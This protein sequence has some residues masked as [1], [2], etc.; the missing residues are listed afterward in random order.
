M[1]GD[2]AMRYEV[3]WE[4]GVEVKGSKHDSEKGA[5]NKARDKSKLFRMAQIAEYDDDNKIKR[6]WTYEYGKQTALK[7]DGQEVDVE[8]EE[9]I[10]LEAKEHETSSQSAADE[11]TAK[12][13]RR[14][15]PATA[16]Q[17]P[18][19]KGKRAKAEGDAAEDKASEEVLETLDDDEKENVTMSPKA[20]KLY[21]SIGVREGSTRGKIAKVLL[22]NMSKQVPISRIGKTAKVDKG[23][24]DAAVRHIE[25]KIKSNK[26]G[27]QVKR[28][29]TSDKKESTVGI[30]SK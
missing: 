3:R 19:K 2:I 10:K 30:H 13:G 20:E 7:V 9:P 26:V 21:E 27:L 17:Q 28:G 8:A 1:K 25:F 12:V 18:T 11:A 16:E 5:K 24:V 6:Q 23:A 15:K 29:Q 14:K 4:D 22:A